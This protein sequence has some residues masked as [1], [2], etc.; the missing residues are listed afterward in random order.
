MHLVRLHVDGVRNLADLTLHAHPRLNVLLGDNGQGKTNLLEAIHLAAALRPLRH[1]ERTAE[2]VAF[3][4]ERGVVRADFSLDGPLT[5]EVTCEPKGRRATVAGKAVR[6]VGELWS[7]IGVVAFV[8]EDIAMVRGGPDGRRAALD[9]FAYGLLP[10]FGAVARRFDEAL[11][12][13]NRAL[14]ADPIDWQLLD[15]F[16]VPYAQAAAALMRARHEACARWAPEIVRQAQQIGAGGLDVSARYKSELPVQEG[17]LE[18][19]LLDALH[20]ARER[21]GKRQSTAVGPHHDDVVLEKDERRA[22]YLSSQ[23]E[24]RALVL[25]MKLAAVTLYTE[26]RG[27]APLLLLD[28]VAGELDPQRQARLFSCVQD[29][30]AQTFVTAT[31][32]ALLPPLPDA[33]R[34]DVARGRV[35]QRASV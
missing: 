34:F 19:R 13:R 12:Q 3:G 33:L 21:E 14:K 17:D 6:D 23:G 10:G 15:S 35:H 24:A 31:H 4:R 2:L 5:V 9:R 26:V 29:S 18:A 20:E 7:R 16:A 1:L 30:G 28:D 22:R 8:P 25:A 27:T 32:D 11:Q